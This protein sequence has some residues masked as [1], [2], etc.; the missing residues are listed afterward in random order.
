[1]STHFAASDTAD[2]GYA[3][4]Q[5]R[6]FTEALEAIRA[7]GV[8][9]GIVHSSNSGAILAHR[10]SW[11]DM[12]RPGIMAYGYYPSSEQDRVLDL[13]PVMELRSKVVFIKEI[14]AGEPVSYGMKWRAPR[15][16]SI[17]TIPI[18]YGD[19][20]NRLLT[21]RGQVLIGDARYPVVGTVCMDQIMVDLGPE[22]RVSR[23]Q[24]AVLFGYTPNAETAESIARMCGTIPYEVTSWVS[25]RVPRVPI[26]SPEDAIRA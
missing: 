2:T 19:G 17:G 21:N 8:D 18:G 14:E 26:S 7:A 12:L 6:R 1:M 4:H 24:D 13:K 10:D 25:S 5:I 20:Y 3:E 23:F 15:R 9:P 16:T 22:C 11:S